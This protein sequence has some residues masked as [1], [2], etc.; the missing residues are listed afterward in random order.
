MTA[1]EQLTEKA[2]IEARVETLRMAIETAL[3]VRKVTL[4]EV[5]RA[6]L[7][8]CTDPTLLDRWD[9]RALTVENESEIFGG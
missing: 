9:E 8:G 3:A 5:G 4:S 6:R 1:A 7:D 2:R